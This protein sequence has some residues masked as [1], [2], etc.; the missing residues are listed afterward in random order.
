MKKAPGNRGFF[1]NQIKSSA[2][3]AAA[4]PAV[5]TQ[6]PFPHKYSPHDRAR[7]GTAATRHKEILTLLIKVSKILTIK[8]LRD[9][10][11]RNIDC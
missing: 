9:F 3:D 4:N 6:K 7:N 8:P 10:V 11:L 5:R 2:L 1:F